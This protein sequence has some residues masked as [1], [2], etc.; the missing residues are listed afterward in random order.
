MTCPACLGTLSPSPSLA[1]VTVALLCVVGIHA[2]S[3]QASDHLS[4]ART[5]Q[6][7]ETS[8]LA[9]ITVLHLATGASHFVRWIDQSQDHQGK[10]FFLVDKTNA[11][12]YVFDHHAQLRAR[13]PVLLG[14]AIGDDSVPGIGTR[15]MDQILPSERTT[16]AGRFVAEA[17]RNANG[18]DVVWV[19]HAAAVSMHRIRS[20]TPGE[21]RARRMASLTVA[22]NRISY[23][24]INV[25]V[26]FYNQHV[27]PAFT[28]SS[29]TAIVYVLPET[30]SL[31]QQ[32]GLPQAFLAESVLD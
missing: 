31:Q 18:E 11:T 5:S 32:F 29:P 6:A 30:R 22:D 9:D 8:A 26:A 2:T 3:V 23:G 1:R 27:Q 25:P 13:T 4:Y 21:E 28:R 19:D 16:P 24:C 12:L 17:G 10:A 14:A 15:P 20:G 7:D